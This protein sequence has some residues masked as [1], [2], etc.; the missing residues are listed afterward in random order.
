MHDWRARIRAWPRE[1]FPP[2]PNHPGE[3]EAYRRRFHN[4]VALILAYRALGTIPATLV[5]VDAG[6]TVA[7]SPTPIVAMAGVYV[8]VATATFF[9]TAN[10]TLHVDPGYLLRRKPL[11]VGFGQSGW[12]DHRRVLELDLLV[13]LALNLLVAALVNQGAAYDEAA[14]VMAVANITSVMLWTGRRGGWRGLRVV[15]LVAI[16]EL[17]KGTANGV[18]LDGIDYGAVAIRL[19]WVLCGWVVAIGVVRILLDYAE[20]AERRRIEDDAMVVI[21]RGHDEYLNA[22]GLVV[23]LLDGVE[24][25][26]AQNARNLALAA[27]TSSRPDPTDGRLSAIAEYAA[28]RGRAAN[29]AMMFDVVDATHGA[30]VANKPEHLAAALE[31]LCINAAR[32]SK[33]SRTTVHCNLRLDGCA[34]VSVRDNGIG[35]P[36]TSPT[37]GGIGIARRAAET[38]G[39][40]VHRSE[41]PRGT[42]WVFVLPKDAVSVR[43]AV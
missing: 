38:L 25:T 2:L 7:S 26:D 32:Y 42:M 30:V 36:M 10:F 24:G 19:L 28:S 11:R 33:G 29:P 9:L 13:A 17:L 16:S 21:W 23:E 4:A 39:G 18:G 34:E 15:G 43:E 12:L 37:G 22:L 3:T 6:S 41:V 40:D 8:G 14:Q 31:N 1:R 27:A 5:F 20:R 35:M